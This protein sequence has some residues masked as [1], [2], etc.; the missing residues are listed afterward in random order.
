MKKFFLLFTLI[1]LAHFTTPAQQG[2]FE[3]TSGT[4]NHLNSVFFIDADNGWAVGDSGTI[5]HTSDGGNNWNVQPS[6]TTDE[7]KSVQF[8]DINNGWISGWST[9]LRTTDEGQNWIDLSDTLATSCMYFI[10]DS[11]GWR[12]TVDDLESYIYKTT[13]GAEEVESFTL[14]SGSVTATDDTFF[15]YTGTTFS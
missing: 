6:T 1:L 9:L 10:N 8:V 13:N 4:T 5:I 15:K 2:W 11:I 3:Q 12:G 14:I 7:L